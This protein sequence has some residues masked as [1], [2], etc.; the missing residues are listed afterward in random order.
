MI[1]GTSR[2]CPLHSAA[3]YGTW[4]Q[5]VISRGH[6]SLVVLYP[7]GTNTSGVCTS[8]ADCPA[9]VTCNAQTLHCNCP[10]FLD[11]LDRCQ[12]RFIDARPFAV[13]ATGMAGI[14]TFLGTLGLAV[15]PLLHEVREHRRRQR[16]WWSPT[17]MLV[18]AA[19]LALFAFLCLVDAILLL[20]GSTTPY[21][22][23]Y[24]TSWST[25]ALVYHVV[26]Y[27]VGRM[28]LKARGLGH[29]PRRWRTTIVVTVSIGVVATV[30]QWAATLA[31]ILSVPS[32]LLQAL[33]FTG[34]GIGFGAPAIVYAVIGGW[35][36]AWFRSPARADE[37]AATGLDRTLTRTIG[38]K[39]AL[40]GLIFVVIAWS[41]AT[42]WMEPLLFDTITLSFVRS[43]TL[44]FLFCCL[45]TAFAWN[46]M[47][48]A[49]RHRA[50]KLRQR[51]QA[52]GGGGAV[53]S[54][55]MPTSATT[56]STTGSTAS[57]LD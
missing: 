48:E 43:C 16:A 52:P 29:L 50:H 6:M 37:L 41:A 25:V 12:T 3:T 11:P 46:G 19:V 30:L 18:H 39:L 57:T 28:F 31:S 2:H 24:T 40:D 54:E 49:Q 45:A 8:D 5:S 15:A 44:C 21:G 10:L 47:V 42:A 35:A 20:V 22:V 9:G 51:Q 34:V 17:P 26:N 56:T 13:W 32:R 55:T 33:T 23:L 4:S 38:L 1:V 36:L 27:A 14:I 53:A 7:S